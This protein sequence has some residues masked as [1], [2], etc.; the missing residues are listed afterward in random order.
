LDEDNDEYNKSIPLSN[1]DK[2]VYR[3]E[4]GI[5]N[6]NQTIPL[7]RKIKENIVIVLLNKNFIMF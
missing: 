5:D 4:G 7:N 3:L 6:Y 2:K 1:D